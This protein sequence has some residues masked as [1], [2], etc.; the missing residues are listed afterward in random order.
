[1][2]INKNF[3]NLSENS[4]VRWDVEIGVKDILKSAIEALQV[5]PK[6]I[7]NWVEIAYFKKYF[8]SLNEDEQKI[9]RHLIKN[10]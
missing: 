2:T 1:M 4:N 6:R 9:V 3:L 5:D 7:Y 10:K 8:E